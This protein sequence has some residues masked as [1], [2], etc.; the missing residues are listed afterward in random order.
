MNEHSIHDEHPHAHGPGCGHKVIQHEGHQDYLHDGHLHF[1]H[2]GHVDEHV[3][4]VGAMNEQTSEVWT[5]PGGI[6]PR[7]PMFAAQEAGLVSCAAVAIPVGSINGQNIGSLSF[8]R[9]H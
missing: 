6:D 1:P 7:L 3:I 8:A 5:V 2:E 9:R 4:A